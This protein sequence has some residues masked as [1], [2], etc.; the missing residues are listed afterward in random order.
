MVRSRR[1]LGSLDDFHEAPA[2]D[3]RQRTALAHDHGVADVGVVGLVVGVQRA[4]DADDLFVPPVAPGDV[5]ANGDGLV[6]LVGD[7]HALAGL[8]PP[9]PVFARRG[10]LRDGAA[11]ARL[12]A[13][14]GALDAPQLG[15]LAP[16][17]DALGVALLGG[18]GLADR[19]LGR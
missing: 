2:L 18:A 17:G 8:L 12:L 1:S 10:R 14:A 4:R 16:L 3:A 9:G 15:L 19:R 5:D 7:D 11:L 13:C 6:G